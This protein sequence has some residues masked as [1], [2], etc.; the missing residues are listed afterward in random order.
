MNLSQ[1]F[2]LKPKELST[3]QHREKLFFTNN[4]NLFFAALIV[5]FF[6]DKSEFE[7]ID[8]LHN[9]EKA[10]LQEYS[11][12]KRRKSYYYGRI[13]GKIAVSDYLNINYQDFYITKGV[14]SQ[15]IVCCNNNVNCQVSISHTDSASAS[16]AFDEKHPMGI[17]IEKV[18]N[19]NSEILKK[20]F[21]YNERQLCLNEIY[22]LIIWTA[23]E[24]VSKALKMGLTIPLNILE[25]NS[26][27]ESNRIYSLSFKIFSQFKAISFLYKENI[28]SIAYPAT[29]QID[30]SNFKVFVSE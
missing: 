25:I 11:Y 3:I 5:T 9:H 15:P 23:K 14:F 16:I 13:S 30:I 19:K 8:I 18:D 4:N 10:Q 26:I 6:D 20:Y 21:T 2:L 7:L 12:K 1:G 17:D 28:I 22:P 24:A 29:S 27:M